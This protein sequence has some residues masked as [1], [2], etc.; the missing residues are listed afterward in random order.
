LSIEFI[1]VKFTREM[2]STRCIASNALLTVRNCHMYER[3]IIAMTVYLRAEKK[4]NRS[5]HSYTRCPINIIDEE[6]RW[7]GGRERDRK[8]NILETNLIIF[9]FM[10]R[11]MTSP[12]SFYKHYTKIREILQMRETL[13]RN[14][15][16]QSCLEKLARKQR[17]YL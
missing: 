4:K 10:I 16:I 14:S 1:R 5:I 13:Q 2:N 17:L 6:R 9:F 11:F 15:K 12:Q 3:D 7:E 8:L